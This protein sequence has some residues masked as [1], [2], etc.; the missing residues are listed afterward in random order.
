LAKLGDEPDAR[1]ASDSKV[2][3]A[4]IFA[5]FPETFE[6]FPACFDGEFHSLGHSTDGCGFAAGARAPPAREGRKT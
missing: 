6:R 1:T 2:K 5:D 4:K 3:K